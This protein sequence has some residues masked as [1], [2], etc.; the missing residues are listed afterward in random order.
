MKVFN[1][2]DM[3]NR[4]LAKLLQRWTLSATVAEEGTA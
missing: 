1:L 3:A 2:A 4:R